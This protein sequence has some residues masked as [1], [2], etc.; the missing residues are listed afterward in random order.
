M[1]NYSKAYLKIQKEQEAHVEK[2]KRIIFNLLEL[3]GVSQIDG[4]TIPGT[5]PVKMVTKKWYSLGKLEKEFIQVFGKCFY[6]KLSVI[7]MLAHK[8]PVSI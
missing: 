1:K 5:P 3:N 7:E 6:K 2:I 4:G 8:T